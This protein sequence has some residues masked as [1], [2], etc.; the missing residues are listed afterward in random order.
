MPDGDRIEI[1]GS[2]NDDIS[3]ALARIEARIKS[4]EDE[5]GKLGRTG[6]KAG[7]EFAG[8]VDTAAEAADN[9]GDQARQARR[10]VK[11]LGDEAVKTG[12]K[13][14]A[15]GAGL[16]GFGKRADRAGKKAKL[17]RTTITAF[18]FA[19]VVTAVFALAGGISALG[20]GAAI[21]IGG[22]APLSGVLAGALPLYAAAKLSMVAWKLAAT[23]LEPVLTRIKNQ[24]TELGPT[25][26]KGGLQKGLDYFANSIG[27]L[28]S[29]TGRGLAGLGAEI[30]G[31]ARHAG[32]MAK[33]APFLAQV[34][35]IFTG[36]RPVV[37]NLANGLLFLFRA[38]MNI[39]EA[40]LPMARDMSRN[41]LD[42]TISMKRWTAAN[43][44]NGK[45]TAWLN[46]SWAQFKRTVGT[47]W[48]FL[49]GLF[50]IFKIGAG[51]SREMGLSIEKTAA[52]FRAW[53]ESAA[54]QARIN[55]YFQDSLP[56][57][58]E[59]GKL[60][61]MMMRGLGSLG[62]NANVAPLLAQIRTEFAPAFSD[63]VA[64]ISGQGG[65]G[66][67][68]ISAA[69]AMVKFMAA[70]DF[71]ALT[72]FLQALASVINGIVWIM[73]NVPGASA[74]VSSLLGAF[75]G[76]KLLGPVWSLVGKGAK[77][78]AWMRAATT[79]TGKLSTAQK[80]MGGIII[81]TIR[82]LAGMLGGAL[83][84]AIKAVG[85][86]IRFA[87]VTTPIGWI[88]L[89]V[90]ALVAAFVYLWNHSAAFRDFFIGVWNAIKIAFWAVI[91]A[92]VTAWT[93]TIDAI[94]TAWK[95]C[96]DFVIMVAGWIW[97][98]G[99]KQVVSVVVTGFKIAFSIVSF[100]VQTA[101]YII[102]GII[103][104]LAIIFRALW[105]GIAHVAQWVF[106]TII[107]PVVRFFQAIW[108]AIVNAARVS[109]EFFVAR[110]SALWNGFYNGVIAPVVN[111]IRGLWNGLVAGLGVAWQMFVQRISTIWNGF[112]SIVSTVVG[113]IKTVW[114]GLTSWL[115]GIFKP[116][117]NA[118]G[119]VFRGI[120]NAASAA[121]KVVKGIWDTIVGAVKA[122]WNFIAKGWNS[123][124]EIH[125]PDWVPA[126]GGSTFGLPKLPVLWHGGEAPGGQALVGEHGPEPLVVGGRVAGILGASGPEVASIPPGGYVVPNL[127]TLSALPG[128][129][130]TLPSSVA[131][132]VARSVPGYA[133]AL[134]P[135]ASG[136]GDG[137]LGSAIDRLAD[138]INGQL[139]P[140]HVHG[141]SDIEAEV[142][143]AWRRLRREDEAR[144]RYKYE[145][146][147]G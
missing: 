11:E 27:K 117:G 9:L 8:G 86:A 16:D 6:A 104:V 14:E 84:T 4:A 59:M 38:L 134:G 131:A 112:K 57:L 110:I 94:T 67:A 114:S 46:R 68:L 98:H 65:L 111:F 29:A 83:V 122:V 44:A 118:I 20:A 15:A 78:F 62:T 66:P 34:S 141:V 17:L 39:V 115:S 1:D 55:K 91:N 24:F 26:A 77:A 64:N 142:L 143:A 138:S 69:T 61:G 13:V 90:A 25:I 19:G 12:V 146:A 71:N 74:L 137:G 21:A 32:N 85:I 53:T 82:T 43:L 37:R 123:I 107:L 56:A 125:V 63:L 109:W 103:T 145:T 120:G 139:P 50:N 99:L 76:F 36:L 95:A 132:A 28:A 96:V 48:D 128:L 124:P 73:Q 102:V 49:V 101:V 81:P 113:F 7:A 119:A 136:G 108:T 30:G 105:L 10:P 133:D 106:N 60:F 35:R 70:L 54:G 5:I 129:T 52:K 92:I 33:Q 140:V 147:G 42:A 22:L 127:S 58:R 40:A 89:A 75:L 80:Y 144:G 31:A 72:L 47:L 88:I 79:L 121:G 45:M 130:K 126:I 97:D 135:P 2:L 93:A 100:I 23:Q 116:V 51:Y 87:F 41:F 18:K 3:E